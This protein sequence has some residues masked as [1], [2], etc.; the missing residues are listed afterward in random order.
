M[1][2]NIVGNGE[3][4]F[5]LTIHGAQRIHGASAHA[6]MHAVGYHNV[7]LEL[8]VSARILCAADL[9]PNSVPKKEHD[10]I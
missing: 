5:R 9:P 6:C 8:F 3:I 4:Y 7:C 1:W 2:K 10:E